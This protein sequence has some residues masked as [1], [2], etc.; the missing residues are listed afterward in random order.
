MSDLY[1]FLKSVIIFTNSMSKFWLLRASAAL[2]YYLIT[3]SRSVSTKV[4]IVLTQAK[5][6]PVTG[7][8]TITVCNF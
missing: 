7:L 6:A 5:E 4:G 8:G 2:G 1:E 3:S